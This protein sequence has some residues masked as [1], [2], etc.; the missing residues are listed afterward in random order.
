MLGTLTIEPAQ[1]IFME[2]SGLVLKICLPQIMGSDSVIYEEYLE[3][4]KIFT[5]QYQHEL[6]F[7]CAI[8]IVL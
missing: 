7:I 2:A 3:N 8:K 4:E 1:K 6:P 5:V